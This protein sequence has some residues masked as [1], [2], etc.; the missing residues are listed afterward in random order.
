[1]STDELDESELRRTTKIVIDSNGEFIREKRV[2]RIISH[3]E[4]EI[5]IPIITKG[6]TIRRVFFP[7]I[8]DAIMFGITFFLN[9]LFIGG[10]TGIG[11]FDGRMIIT[12]GYISFLFAIPGMYKRTVT[13][14]NRRITQLD[15]M[16]SGS[17]NQI[18]NLR[19]AGL[20][21]SFLLIVIGN[22]MQL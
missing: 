17:M 5:P 18:T 19:L 6:E 12:W 21:G 10:L 7:D 11:V 4:I 14:T 20:T 15:L 1:M 22:I 9:F 16:A 13:F 2:Q 3:P 8:V